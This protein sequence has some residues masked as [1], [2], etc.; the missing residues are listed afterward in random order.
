MCVWCPR[1][2]NTDI[3]ELSLSGCIL[4][5]LIL[6]FKIRSGKLHPDKRTKGEYMAKEI[7]VPVNTI[8]GEVKAIQNTK[9]RN[10]CAVLYPDSM[11]PFWQDR[12]YR[13]IQVP[14]EYIIHDKDSVEL[15]E[16][17]SEPRKV[18]VHINLHFD[19]PTTYNNVYRLLVDNL[20]ALGKRCCN[21]CE[22][23]VRLKYMHMYLTHST[24]DAIK[25]GKFRYDDKEVITGNNWDLG[26]FVELEECE[27]LV[28]YTSIRK[29][30]IENKF[31]CVIDLEDYILRG[32]LRKD[33]DFMDERQ[34]IQYISNN[35]PK[36]VQICKEVHFKFSKKEK[37]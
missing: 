13:L 21:K 16:D 8:T 31:F 5:V 30:I 2:D 37:E 1:E 6:V 33:I 15:E 20:S 18:H 14:F 10:W 4:D 36:F 11:I 25:D 9:H 24:P 17:E 35:R 7:L 3:K 23:I 19:G 34:L 32:G 28:L 12:I 27:R 22:G 29:T 26:A